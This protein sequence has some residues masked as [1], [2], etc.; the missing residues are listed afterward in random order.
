MERSKIITMRRHKAMCI[1]TRVSSW[2]FFFFLLNSE[3]L[4]PSLT[5]PPWN[6]WGCE[7]KHT[8]CHLFP[9]HVSRHWYWLTTPSNPPQIHCCHFL[10]RGNKNRTHCYCSP[11]PLPVSGVCCDVL[12]YTA[13]V[14]LRPCN[15]SWREHTG[16]HPYITPAWCA[17]RVVGWAEEAGGRGAGVQFSS[18]LT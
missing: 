12:I 16:E 10:T 13:M 2:K 3:A 9:P 8:S 18:G 1:K 4:L 7:Q 11:A 5:K 14:L 6:I 17:L 15:F